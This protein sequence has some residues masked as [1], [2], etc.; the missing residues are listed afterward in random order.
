MKRLRDKERSA[1]RGRLRKLI[2]AELA[3]LAAL[4]PS[5]DSKTARVRHRVGRH[6]SDA[7][8]A[9]HV[10]VPRQTLSDWL[11]GNNE[12][13]LPQL[14]RLSE[15]TRVSLDWLVFGEGGDAPVYRGLSR[16]PG[17]LTADLA[18][19]VAWALQNAADRGEF[20]P[21]EVYEGWAV[22]GTRVLRE[23]IDC[24]IA[25]F[26]ARRDAERRHNTLWAADSRIRLA[27]H[28]LTA[29]L[30]PDVSEAKRVQTVLAHCREAQRILQEVSDLMPDSPAPAAK[31]REI[32]I[33]GRIREVTSSDPG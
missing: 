32:T 28:T 30:R 21:D 4:P 3:R 7:A 1:L 10:R 33:Q 23:T 2:R 12:P 31:A 25:K 16:T 17:Q 20:L 27:A 13:S 18:N 29:E 5:R 14:I 19:E 9:E 6:D 8:F 22:D 26:R 15:R 24:E 11:A